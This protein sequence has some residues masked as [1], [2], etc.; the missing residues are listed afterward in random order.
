[1]SEVVC[2]RTKNPGR[3]FTPDNMERYARRIYTQVFIQDITSPEFTGF[4]LPLAHATMKPIRGLKSR[5]T[6]KVQPRPSFLFLPY[7]VTTMSRTIHNKIKKRDIPKGCCVG[8]IS[9]Y[10]LQTPQVPFSL[11]QCLQYLQFLHAV[12]VLDP[13]QAASGERPAAANVIDPMS[14]SRPTIRKSFF[15]MSFFFPANP[16]SIFHPDRYD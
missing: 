2:H 12:H 15:F 7:R 3:V 1:M 5:L 6:T 8:S 16:L 11:A 14:N 4:F 9:I 10:F 13:V